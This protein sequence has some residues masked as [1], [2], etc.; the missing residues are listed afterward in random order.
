MVEACPI[1]GRDGIKATNDYTTYDRFWCEGCR[2]IFTS[3][4]GFE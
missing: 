3:V 2:Y 4:V 1:C